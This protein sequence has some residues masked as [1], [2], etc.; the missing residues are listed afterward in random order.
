MLTVDDVAEIIVW[1]D[2]R[3]QYNILF[4]FACERVES[5]D[6]ESVGFGCELQPKSWWRNYMYLQ[7]LHILYMYTY[8]ILRV[9]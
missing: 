7:I 9:W 3:R 8:V 4:Y 5:R 2:P 6:R 1:Y